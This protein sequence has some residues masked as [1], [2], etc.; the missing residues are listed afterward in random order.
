VAVEERFQSW[1]AER[2]PQ[3]ISA[4]PSA[5]PTRGPGAIR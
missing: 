3:R 1:N 2:D 4:A 5:P